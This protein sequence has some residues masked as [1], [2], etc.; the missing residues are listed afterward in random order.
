MNDDMEEAYREGIIGR[1]RRIGNKKVRVMSDEE[2]IKDFLADD[3]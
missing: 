1:N 2:Y 3:E